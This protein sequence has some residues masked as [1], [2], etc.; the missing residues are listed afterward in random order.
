MITATSLT[1][2]KHYNHLIQQLV[3][4]F[5][6]RLKTVV[7][8]GS[9]AR[10]EAEDTSDH[11]LLLV[12]DRLPEEPVKRL[13]TVRRAIAEVPLCIN[14]IAKTPSEVAC[15]LTSLLLDVCVDGICLFGQDY[16]DPYRRKALQALQQSGLKRKR[17]GRTWYWQFEQFP[18]RV[19]ELTWDGYREL[20]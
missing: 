19:W 20:P 17:E 14:T 6:Q 1:D 2:G 8:F 13:K 7:L 12:I 15:N 5:G 11:D 3:N 18:T 16:F 9:R 4:N 10:E